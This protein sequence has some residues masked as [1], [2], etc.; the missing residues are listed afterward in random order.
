MARTTSGSTPT[1][2]SAAFLGTAL[3][4]GAC[5][6]G[7]GPISHPSGSDELVLRIETVGGFVPPSFLLGRVPDLSIFGDGRVIVLGPQIAIF[8]GPALPN[9]VTFRLSEA[10]L[11]VLLENARAAGLLGPDAHYDYPFI[12]DAPT[13][14][15]TVVADGRRHVISAYALSLGGL[16]EPQ[17]DP[18]VRRARAALAAFQAR[19]FDLRSW[20]AGE[21]VEPE[22]AYDFRSIRQFVTAAGQP[23]EPGPDQPGDIPPNFIEWPLD[24]PLAVFGDPMTNLE[25]TRCGVVTGGDLVTLLPAL[26]DANDLTLWQ[27]GSESYRLTLRPLLPDESGCPTSI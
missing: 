19:A 2:L 13:T 25:G 4:V 10:G 16:G 14:S 24:V 27:S 1:I 15:F 12:A 3:L 21:I 11:Q 18:E 17:L 26:R 20:L 23:D 7:S 5:T 6:G 8:P 22:T 9:L